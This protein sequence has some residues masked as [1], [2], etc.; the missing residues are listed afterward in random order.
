MTD[1]IRKTIKPTLL[2]FHGSGSNAMIH[3]VQF[4]RLSKYLNPTFEIVHLEGPFA[5]AAGPGVLPFFEGCGPY[6]RWVP[7]TE[8]LSTSAMKN[9]EGSS[10]MALETETLVRT[11]I[12]EIRAK[13]GRVVGL[14]GFSQG[15]RIIAGLLK[16]AE[17]AARLQDDGSDVSALDWLQD[18][19]F[20]ISVCD[21]Y[22]P[23]TLP[24]S[25]TKTLS[26]SLVSA[27]QQ[28]ALLREKIRKPAIHVLGKQDEWMW[29]GR[30]FVE[31]VYEVKEGQSEVLEA[32]V[33]HQYPIEVRD[34]ERIWAWVEGVWKA[35]EGGA[36]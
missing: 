1:R 35:A 34:T 19:E 28:E 29:A 27:D 10:S 7:L 32:D 2:A 12:S 30:L 17:I 33:G 6:K 11:T 5:S 36:R 16:G 3:T 18:L 25:V 13:G 4:A 20:G 15:T 21:S 9:G 24:L 22:P 23:A 26:S 14:I 8:Q 31:Q